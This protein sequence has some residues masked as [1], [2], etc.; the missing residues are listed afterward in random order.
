MKKSRVGQLSSSVVGLLTQDM[1]VLR[2]IA[3]GHIALVYD[4]VPY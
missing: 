2:G 1:Y 3:I 4:L